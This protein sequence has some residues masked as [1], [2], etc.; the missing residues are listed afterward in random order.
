MNFPNMKTNWILIAIWTSFLAVCNLASGGDL[1]G[2]YILVSAD[3]TDG[4]F[5]PHTLDAISARISKIGDKYE[6]TIDDILGIDP[7]TV[8]LY[9]DGKKMSF[10]LPPRKFSRDGEDHMSNAKA[11][12]GEIVLD[13]Y[14]AGTVTYGEKLDAF[15]LKRVRALPAEISAN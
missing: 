3:L 10:F 7:S 2:D 5:D 4:D 15:K 11:Y 9:I 12:F 1:L 6:I 8:P 13:L 14:I